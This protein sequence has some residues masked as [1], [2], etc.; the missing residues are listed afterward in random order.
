MS[1]S[2]IYAE[3]W[4][5]KLQERLSEPTKW[6][7]ICN[8]EYTNMKVLHNPY[9]ADPTVQTGI[10]GTA[11]TMQDAD[12]TDDTITINQ[13]KILPQVIDRA[14][15]AQ[16]TYSSQ[17]ILADRQGVLLDEAIETAVF[18]SYASL[19]SFG[20]T[21]GGVLG[22]AATNIT[23]SATNIDDIIRGIKEQINIAKGQKIAARNGVFIVWRPQ[24]MAVLESFMQANGFLTADKALSGK[25]ATESEFSATAG[26]IDYMGVTHYAS[27]LLT[28]NHVIAG[29]K[30]VLHLGIVKDTYGQVVITQDPLNVSGIGV[31]SRVDYAVKAW[32]NVVPILFNVCVN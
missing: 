7:E 6:K 5:V 29:V 21:G 17:M 12:Q 4:S 22:L 13:Y 31:I 1:N 14:D 30:K 18:A 8:V 24:D 23:V 27:N 25:G 26:G 16:S 10:R 20:D 32:H 2:L 15:L 28:A 11:Y 9:M 3:D 19:T